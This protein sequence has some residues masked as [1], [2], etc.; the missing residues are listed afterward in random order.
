VEL[1]WRPAASD[2]SFLDFVTNLSQPL[3]LAR[4]YPPD[5]EMDINVTIVTGEGF[6]HVSRSFPVNFP[7]DQLDLADLRDSITNSLAANGI[8]FQPKVYLFAP[9]GT[10]C[11]PLRSPISS[12]LIPLSCEFFTRSISPVRR[13]PISR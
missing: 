3:D 2:A 12:L 5:C 10:I 4:L 9:D 13:T 7:A 8:T 11:A 1:G 6:E